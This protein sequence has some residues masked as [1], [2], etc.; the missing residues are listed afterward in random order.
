MSTCREEHRD[1]VASLIEAL[2]PRTSSSV[3]YTLRNSKKKGL[4]A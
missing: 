1:D 4:V 3:S 2:V